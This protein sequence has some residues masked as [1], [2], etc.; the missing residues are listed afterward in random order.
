MYTFLIILEVE[1]VTHYSDTERPAFRLDRP[2]SKVIFLS[3]GEFPS[4]LEK[5][6]FIWQ[7]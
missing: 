2:V 3:F 1:L 5:F 6:L 7:T 4:K